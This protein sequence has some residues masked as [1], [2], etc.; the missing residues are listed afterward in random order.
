MQALCSDTL[1]AAGLLSAVSINDSR[2]LP[3]F[4]D[5]V[6]E[7]CLQAGSKSVLEVMVLDKP[8]TPDNSAVSANG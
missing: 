2:F 4:S 8:T 6:H 5:A 7:G 1:D 3:R